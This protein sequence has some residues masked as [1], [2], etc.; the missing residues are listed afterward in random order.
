MFGTFW[1]SLPIFLFKIGFLI[2]VK[3]LF[4]LWKLATSFTFKWIERWRSE[5]KD[6]KDDSSVETR[7]VNT[8]S[9]DNK[10]NLKDNAAKMSCNR[11]QGNFVSKNVVNLSRRNLTDSEISLLSKGLNFIPTSNTKDKAKL[12]TE[13]EA[14]GRKLRLK[15]HFRNEEGSV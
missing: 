1:E 7:G 14:L 13:L 4:L 10:L 8:S 11:L 12:K 6:L 5:K 3:I 9:I 15:W 2:F